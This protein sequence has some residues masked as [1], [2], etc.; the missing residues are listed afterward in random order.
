ML[1]ALKHGAEL[2]EYEQ[3][4]ARLLLVMELGIIVKRR[5][6]ADDSGGLARQLDARIAVKPEP[7]RPVLQFINTQP[8]RNLAEIVV[9]G[10]LQ[11]LDNGLVRMAIG[12]CRPALNGVA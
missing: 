1:I 4:N 6:S 11:R 5:L 8:V 2:I 3:G 7:A 9:A 12:P 10:V